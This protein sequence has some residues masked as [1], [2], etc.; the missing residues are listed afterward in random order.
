[1]SI[2]NVT[3]MRQF[4]REL[5][6]QARVRQFTITTAESCTGG[7]LAACLTEIPNASDIFMQSFV[8]YHNNAKMLYLGVSEQILQNDGAVSEKCAAQMA[9]GAWQ[10]AKNNLPETHQ[11][12]KILAIAITGI[13]GDSLSPMAANSKNANKNANKNDTEKKAGLVFISLYDGDETMIYQH[14]FQ[15]NRAAVRYQ[16]VQM[17]LEHASKYLEQYLREL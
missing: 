13:A 6:Q 12:K 1:M 8:T 14:H 9:I 2:N 15:G 3:N 17:A 4:S 16:T 10:Q 5:L 11:H 7:L